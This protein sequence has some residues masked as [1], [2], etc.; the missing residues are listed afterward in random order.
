MTSTRIDTTLQQERQAFKRVSL[1]SSHLNT[2]DAT[3]S[4]VGT[5]T[6]P[7]VATHV[8][9]EQVSE[10]PINMCGGD[11]TREQLIGWVVSKNAIASCFIKDV[12]SMSESERGGGSRLPIWMLLQLIPTLASDRSSLLLS[13]SRTLQISFVGCHRGRSCSVRTPCC[14]HM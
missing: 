2:V 12:L 7:A 8:D 10:L 9:N 14:L 4:T 13:R 6:R 11:H 1:N 3:R 5:G